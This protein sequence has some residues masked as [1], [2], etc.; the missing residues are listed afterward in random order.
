MILPSVTQVLRPFKDFGAI[1]DHI[2]AAAQERGTAFHALAASVLL[3]TWIP[4]VP[5]IVEGFFLSFSRWAAAHVVNVVLVE[6]TLVHP[7]L[8]YKGTPDALLRI[9]GDMGFTLMD[10]KTPRTF[11]KT[12]V[13]QIAAYR[14]LIIKNGYQVDRVATLQPHPEGKAPMFREFTS[15]MTVAWAA[16]QS[17]LN[18]WRYFGV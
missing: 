9:R 2:M 13:A 18:C 6:R 7:I 4:E 1:P 16:F 11:S 10:W 8:K 12:W 14:E 5:T 3:N 15:S 17:A